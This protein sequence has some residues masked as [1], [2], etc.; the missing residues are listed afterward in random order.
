M[1]NILAVRHPLYVLHIRYSLTGGV[2]RRRPVKDTVGR[3]TKWDV[4]SPWMFVY[5][6]SYQ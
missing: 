5:P 2:V 3:T 4:R 6:V 1:Y